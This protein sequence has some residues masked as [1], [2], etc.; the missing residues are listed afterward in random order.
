[1]PR[2]NIIIL[3][4]PAGDNTTFNYIFWADVPAGRQSRYASSTKVSAWSGAS[5]TDNANLQSGA[6]VEQPG[7]VRHP[8][9]TPI[10]TVEATLQS[11]WQN[12]QNN[13]TAYNPWQRYGSFWDGSSAWTIVNNP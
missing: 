6:V 5:S 8:S 10:A 2:L 3:D 7:L 4:Q 9:G 12:Y 11:A 1:M 13:I